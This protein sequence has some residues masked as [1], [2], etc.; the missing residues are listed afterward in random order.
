MTNARWSR[1]AFLESLGLGA[2]ALLPVLDAGRASAAP[3]PKRLLVVLQSEGTI[4]NEFWPKGEGSDLTT[5]TLPAPGRWSTPTRSTS[6]LPV[7]VQ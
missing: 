2:T 6:T 4:A 7:R 3:S 5:L 1:R